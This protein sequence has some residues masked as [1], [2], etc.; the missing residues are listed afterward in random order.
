MEANIHRKSWER[1]TRSRN[2]EHQSRLEVKD[3][4]EVGFWGRRKSFH[5]DQSTLKVACGKPC[6]SLYYRTFLFIWAIVKLFKIILRLNSCI[7]S[8]RLGAS[9]R[10][11][12]IS[13]GFI[14]LAFFPYSTRLNRKQALIPPRNIYWILPLK[15]VP[16]IV[17][18]RTRR[19][20]CKAT[21][22]H[23]HQENEDY[24]I[25][26]LRTRGNVVSMWYF[27]NDF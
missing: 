26:L 24:V 23:F 8:L 17:M 4:Y 16:V 18:W 14:K 19:C 2:W 20:R 11:M 15:Q 9:L 27:K 25:S 7:D 6:G 21:T 3:F 22:C 5:K 12:A 1:E 13:I 10:A